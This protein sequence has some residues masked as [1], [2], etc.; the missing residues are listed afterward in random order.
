MQLCT[1]SATPQRH[2]GCGGVREFGPFLVS[3]H[4]II[5]RYHTILRE[6]TISCYDNSC[7][8]QK[9]NHQTS[10]LNMQKPFILPIRM[11]DFVLSS[12]R[13]HSSQ[14][15]AKIEERVP[16]E[17]SNPQKLPFCQA[18]LHPNVSQL[19]ASFCPQQLLA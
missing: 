13:L 11:Y 2:A 17:P 16:F 8:L 5:V 9:Q 12:S 7:C 4:A 1:N 3:Y 19:V 10:N 6:S 15:Q 18:W 14:I